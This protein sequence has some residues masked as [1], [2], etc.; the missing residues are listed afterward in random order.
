MYQN[1]V[2]TWN[3]NLFIHFFFFLFFCNSLIARFHFAETLLSENYENLITA[4]CDRSAM[5]PKLK[6]SRP[7]EFQLII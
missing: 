2:S 1:F 7:T 3:F 5:S 4:D 6:Q